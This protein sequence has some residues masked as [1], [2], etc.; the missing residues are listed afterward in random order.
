MTLFVI[1]RLA[2]N[3]IANSTIILMIVFLIMESHMRG[4]CEVDSTNLSKA[5]RMGYKNSQSKNLNFIPF[6]CA[7]IILLSR[8]APSI[9][10]IMALA[11]DVPSISSISISYPT[12]P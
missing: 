7:S 8:T 1:S 2:S 11:I 4:Y 9:P 12:L 5:F 10:I 6:S 3:K